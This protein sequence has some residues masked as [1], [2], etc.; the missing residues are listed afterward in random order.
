MIWGLLLALFGC[1]EEEPLCPE[2]TTVLAT[3]GS[4]SLACGTAD[5]ALDYIEVLAAREVPKADRERVYATLK[6]RFE[7]DSKGTAADLVDARTKAD[8]LS[9]ARGLE[10]AEGRAAQVYKAFKRQGPLM[11]T[12]DVVVS[13]FARTAQKWAS[14]D[15]TQL[16]LTELDVEGWLYYASLCREVQGAGP[17][18][19][20]IADR[21][22]AYTVVEDIFKAG[23]REEQIAL[24]A[25][26]PFWS[27]VKLKW[28]AASYDEQQA[29]IGSAPLP[30]PMTSSSLG[31]FQAVM[32]AKPSHHAR[33]L[34]EKLG[35]L[36]MTGLR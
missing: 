25:T 5:A 23:S 21:V 22:P 8:E 18:K 36:K 28:A 35:P 1:A 2:A 34:H 10:A 12:D 14:D 7:A 32:E 26:G 24:A 17:L 15:E 4:D 29:W 11:G 19:L 3:S 9:A 30:P 16:A 6:T 27:E 31:Y 20:S 33:V 13:T